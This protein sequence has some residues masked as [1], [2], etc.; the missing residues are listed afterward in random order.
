MKASTRNSRRQLAH[1][2]RDPAAAI[3]TFASLLRSH[4]MG[5]LNA[6]QQEFVDDILTSAR[7]LLGM[8]DRGLGEGPGGNGSGSDGSGGEGTGEGG[9]DDG[10][11]DRGG[12]LH[13]PSRLRH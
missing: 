10:W 1:D 4:K 2:L 6:K 11:A 8:I 12:S 13:R 5:D 3:V 9:S 7:E